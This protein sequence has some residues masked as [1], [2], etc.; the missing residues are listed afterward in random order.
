MRESSVT[1]P[2]SVSRKLEKWE[3]RGRALKYVTLFVPL[4]VNILALSGYGLPRKG[5]VRGATSLKVGD[6]SLT[7]SAAVCDLFVSPSGNDRNKGTQDA[8]WKT[9]QRAFNSAMAGQTVCFRG[10][11]YPQTVTSG[12]QQVENNSGIEGRPI[13][14][15]NYPSE[16][17]IIQGSTRIN[18][19]YIT[20]EGNSGMASNCNA[21]NPCGLVFEG[22]RGYPKDTVD[23]EKSHDVTF[24][25]VEIR[26]GNYH[27]GIFQ[28]GGCN[29]QIIGCYIHDNGGSD[30]STDNGIYFA[31]TAPGCT[32]GGLIL[33]NVVEHNVSKGIQLYSG[34]SSTTPSYVV[35]C[36][37]TVVNNGGYG[38]VIWGDNNTFSYNILYGNGDTNRSAQGAI[39]TGVAQTVDHNITFSPADKSRSGWYTPWYMPGGCCLTNSKIAD[40]K[41]AGPQNKDWHLTSSSPAIGFGNKANTAWMDKDCM[42]RGPGFD[43]GAYQYLGDSR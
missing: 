40:P 33:N 4:A 3:R 32:R 18:G 7:A 28:E 42:A 27:A 10:G 39:Y 31:A 24:D 30:A 41:F 43:A 25:H 13:K 8:P 22:S 38:A 5:F 21:V 9:P 19:S 6:R 11:T 12:Y 23:L 1:L 26:N 17:A 14:F 35:V 16:V 15:T 36:H 20:F 37:N 34:R 29:I 2:K